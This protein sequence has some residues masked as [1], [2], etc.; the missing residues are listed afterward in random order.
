MKKTSMCEKSAAI[1]PCADLSVLAPTSFKCKS[2]QRHLPANASPS[3]ASGRRRSTRVPGRFERSCG[4]GCPG[5][6]GSPRSSCPLRTSSTR[7]TT[8]P[9]PRAAAGRFR[10]T[11][12]MSVGGSRIASMTCLSCVTAGLGMIKLLHCVCQTGLTILYLNTPSFCVHTTASAVAFTQRSR[13]V[14]NTV[15]HPKRDGL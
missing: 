15:F 12:A 6:I 11:G 9:G 8:T 4:P 13:P 3:Q 7:T 5:F 2:R 14:S 1:F 10:A